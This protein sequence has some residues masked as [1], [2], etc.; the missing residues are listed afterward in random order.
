ML[1]PPGSRVPWRS[2]KPGGGHRSS[3]RRS[4]ERHGDVVRDRARPRDRDPGG[5]RPR[6]EPRAARRARSPPPPEHQVAQFRPRTRHRVPP[7]SGD[8]SPAR[9]AGARERAGEHQRRVEFGIGAVA[10]PRGPAAMRAGDAGSRRRR[11]RPRRRRTPAAPRGCTR[12]SRGRT[13]GDLVRLHLV[14]ALPFLVLGVRISAAIAASY[15][16]RFRLLPAAR[17]SPCRSRH[18]PG[19]HPRMRVRFGTDRGTARRTGGD[20]RRRPRVPPVGSRDQPR[21]D[22]LDRRGVPRQPEV[23]AARFLASLLAAIAV[24]G[25]GRPRTGRAPIG[26]PLPP[27]RRAR[28]APAT[29]QHDLLHAGGFLIVGA[30]TAATLQTLVPRA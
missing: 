1:F 11:R 23:V 6:P 16:R 21:R 29:A 12:P 22:G 14:Q 18:R 28:G 25:L 4:A 10:A 17:R 15:R 5:G 20:G 2:L 7:P 24:A 3:E 19:G 9:R 8:P 26:L 30:A 27:R 13:L